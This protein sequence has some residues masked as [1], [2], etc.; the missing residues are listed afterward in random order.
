M[1][2]FA[3]MTAPPQVGT[4]YGP[5]P[6]NPIAR[7]MARFFGGPPAESDADL[8]RGNAGSPGRLRGTARIIRALS[9]ADRLEPGDILVAPTT[10]PPWTPLFG[11]AGAVVTDT[12]GALSHCAIVSR[13]YGIPCVVGV[14]GATA[15]IQDGQEVEVDGDAGTVRLL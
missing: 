15:R 10:S 14:A 5:P 13:E 12:G 6:D 4:D 2:H 3:T 7:A 11:I 1:A 9:D 8:L